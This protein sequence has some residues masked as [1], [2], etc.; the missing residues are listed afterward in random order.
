M[1]ISAH[2]VHYSSV[3]LLKNVCNLLSE[4]LFTFTTLLVKPARG[5]S[6]CQTHFPS[7]KLHIDKIKAQPTFFSLNT[8]FYC[9]MCQFIP[10]YFMLTSALYTSSIQKRKMSFISTVLLLNRYKIK[11]RRTR[12]EKDLQVISRFSISIWHQS[13][14]MLIRFF[15]NQIV[16]TIKSTKGKEFN[17]NH[18]LVTSVNG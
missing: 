8:P 4:W 15:R 6:M 11:C 2:I 1:Y 14:K 3:Q 17:S 7:N 18:Y 12:L 10:F 5:I 9:E 13:L 16:C